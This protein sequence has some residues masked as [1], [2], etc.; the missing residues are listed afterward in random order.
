MSIC[1]NC[2]KSQIRVKHDVGHWWNNP[3]DSVFVCSDKCYTE[4]EKLVKD[5]TWLYHKP[6][7]IFGKKKK[8]EKKKTIEAITDKQF[9]KSMI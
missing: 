4:L 8:A 1:S 5:R 9:S 6:E 3:P 7:A 2:Y